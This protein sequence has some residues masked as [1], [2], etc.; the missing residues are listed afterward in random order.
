MILVTGA[1]GLVGGAVLR[2]LAGR[3][4]AVRALARSPA[5]AAALS[6]LGIETAVADFD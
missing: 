4:V 5:K 1:T 6:G 2:E 3:G